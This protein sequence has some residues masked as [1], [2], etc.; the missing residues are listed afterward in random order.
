MLEFLKNRAYSI[1]IDVGN[2]SLNIAQ[3]QNTDKGVA[4]LAGRS[5]RRPES[6][7]AGS[8][9]W[10]RWAMEAIREAAA[11]HRFHGRNVIAAVPAGD[12]FIEYVKME[13][14]FLEKLQNP[15][16]KPRTN[17]DDKMSKVVFS[18]I[19]QKLPFE[20]D[21]AMIQYIP[22][23]QDSILVMAT[24]RKIIDR[25]LAIYEKA[26]LT[27]KSIGAWPVA[28]TNC[29]ATFFGRRKSDLEAIVMLLDIGTSYTNLVI[30]RHKNPLF[31]CSI[32]MGVGQLDDEK[33][34]TRLVFELNACRSRFAS[35]HPEAQIERLIFLCAS[36][37][38][39]DICKMIAR[40]MKIQAQV[41]DCLAAVQILDPYRL[42]I[43][44]RDCNA[45]W[46]TAFGLGLS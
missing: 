17:N 40:Q 30:C 7:E 46:A 8:V 36:N 11:N 28:L 9:A 26:G 21:D 6:V 45:S 43:D 31:A 29:Y 14:Q 20:P 44:R 23:G 13:P 10:Q 5:E 39:T 22:T 15:D 24:E 33:M 34:V 18:K 2:D 12:M 27:V 4:L 32:L 42:E 16:Q 37:V 19:K 1:G 41:G 25:H 35:M 3:L 38:D